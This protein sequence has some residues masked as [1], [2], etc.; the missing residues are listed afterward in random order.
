[1]INY[2]EVYCDFNDLIS[3]QINVKWMQ[4][5]KSAHQITVGGTGIRK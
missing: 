5:Q 1:M 2:L 4:T 3:T